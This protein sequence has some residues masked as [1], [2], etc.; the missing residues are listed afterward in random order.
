MNTFCSKVIKIFEKYQDSDINKLK[1]INRYLKT[2]INLK[3]NNSEEKINKLTQFY[4]KK[5][6]YFILNTYTMKCSQNC[7]MSFLNISGYELLTKIDYNSYFDEIGIKE[8]C[9]IIDGFYAPNDQ[10]EIIL[11]NN[12]KLQFNNII[13][14]VPFS[15][16]DKDN[17]EIITYIEDYIHLTNEIK[18]NQNNENKLEYYK[19]FYLH[20]LKL[21]KNI[22]DTEEFLT[23]ENSWTFDYFSTH[24]DY[25]N[26]HTHEMNS[27]CKRE[28]KYKIYSNKF[29]YD[30]LKI[31]E[32][33]KNSEYVEDYEYIE[34]ELCGDIK[35][36]KVSI[37]DTRKLGLLQ[38]Y[39]EFLLSR[40]KSSDLFGNTDYII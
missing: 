21:G 8:P 18:I 13:Y 23:F 27:D 7:F 1:I 4:I 20:F 12:D 22:E 32:I 9:Q 2:L 39:I 33:K 16:K 34:N 35:N 25:F 17:N 3:S 28:C 29:I 30:N 31:Q 10:D 6:L 24:C 11:L 5:Y 38:E 14:I 19:N 36:N 26:S 37:Y 15:L 40:T